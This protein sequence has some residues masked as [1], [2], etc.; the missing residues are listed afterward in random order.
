[1]NIFCCSSTGKSHWATLWVVKGFLRTIELEK[2]ILEY[3]LYR[4]TTLRLFAEDPVEQASRLY[5]L[6]FGKPLSL[7]MSVHRAIFLR[8]SSSARLS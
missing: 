3:L 1:M 4:G 2:I 5:I 6:D 8:S 7:S